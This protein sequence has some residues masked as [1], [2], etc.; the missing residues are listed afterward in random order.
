MSLLVCFA[1]IGR[2]ACTH[3]AMSRAFVSY[4]L[5]SLPGLFHQLDC[6]GQSRIDPRVIPGVETIDRRGDACR[7]FLFLRTW[8]VE[9]K[10]RLNLLIVCRKPEALPAAPAE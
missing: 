8:T 10:G 9:D 7:F 2:L 5:I 4:R 3:E 6:L 1:C